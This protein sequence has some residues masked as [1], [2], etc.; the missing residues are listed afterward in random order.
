M[1][2]LT[3]VGIYDCGAQISSAKINADVMIH[4]RLTLLST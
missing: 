3:G 4:E 1:V 2:N